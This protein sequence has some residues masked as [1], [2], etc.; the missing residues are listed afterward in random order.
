MKAFGE[1]LKS[2]IIG[3]LLIIL[4]LGLVIVIVMK[5]VGML[6]PL[7]EPMAAY[8]PETLRFPMLLALALLLILSV[9]AGLL[10]LTSVGR[11]VGRFIESSI[12]DRIPGYSMMR[13]LTHRI[14]DNDDTAKFAPAFVEIEEALVL[15]FIIEEH[16]DGK[17]TVFVPSAPTPAAGSIYVMDAARVHFI[18]APFINAV[19]CVSKF[20]VGS[21]ELLKSLRQPTLT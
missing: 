3:G 7:A 19:R 8:L 6:K 11:V 5:F 14:G 13:S 15:A 20:G 10:A 17:Y 9:A 4:P 12:L 2:T 18:N 21:E 16:D 1:F